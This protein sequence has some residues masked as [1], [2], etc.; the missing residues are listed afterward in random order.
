[1]EG[2]FVCMPLGHWI[3]FSLKASCFMH[4]LHVLGLLYGLCL[5]NVNMLTFHT[6]IFFQ[7]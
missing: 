4:P 1:M 2:H 5:E 6:L 7:S 3:E